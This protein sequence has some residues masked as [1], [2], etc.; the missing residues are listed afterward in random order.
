M[1]ELIRQQKLR[2]AP[3]DI[4]VFDRCGVSVNAARLCKV[5]QPA[6]FTVTLK[7]CGG[8]YSQLFHSF[9]GKRKGAIKLA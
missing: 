6:E 2:S 9:C 5:L 4:D 1:P 3:G 8:W 7:G